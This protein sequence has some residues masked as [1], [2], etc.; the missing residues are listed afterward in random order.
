MPKGKVKWFS[1]QKGYGFITPD[2]GG[3][4]CFVHRSGI[5]GEEEFKVLA[6]EDTVEFEIEK[7]NTG[8]SKAV[9]VRKI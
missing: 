7:D 6:E 5:I 1:R 4:D 2:E 9:K 8:R 3:D